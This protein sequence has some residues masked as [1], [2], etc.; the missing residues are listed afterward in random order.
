LLFFSLNVKKYFSVPIGINNNNNNKVDVIRTYVSA[1]KWW[2]IRTHAI[3]TYLS[4]KHEDVEVVIKIN[5]KLNKSHITIK[6]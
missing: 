5:V 4:K 2:T 3:R 1:N 6:N